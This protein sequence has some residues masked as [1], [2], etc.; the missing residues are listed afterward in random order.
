LDFSS[1]SAPTK[2]V[3]INQSNQSNFI[4]TRY[5][6]TKTKTK[7]FTRCDLPIGR[8]IQGVSKKR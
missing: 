4:Y 6:F 3:P 7:I 1:H 2:F 8:A 5:Y